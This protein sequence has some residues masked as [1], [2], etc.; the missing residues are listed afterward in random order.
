MSHHRGF[1][2]RGIR[3]QVAVVR[4]TL[5]LNCVVVLNTS[6][7][8]GSKI[9]IVAI[10][11]SIAFCIC[12]GFRLVIIIIVIVVV[13]SDRAPFVDLF[14]LLKAPFVF[15]FKDTFVAV[16]KNVFMRD[17]YVFFQ[18]LFLWCS[19]ITLITLVNDTVVFPLDM[20]FQYI[21]TL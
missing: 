14:M 9:T 3:A 19:K 20:G 12:F 4:D 6:F 8:F 7:I 2:G 16:K 5:M 1:P 17:L 10:I 13:L 11:E 15:G 18:S 21:L